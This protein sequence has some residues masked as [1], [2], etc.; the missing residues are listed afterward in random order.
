MDRRPGETTRRVLDAL[1]DLSPASEQRSSTLSIPTEWF[2]WLPAKVVRLFLPAWGPGQYDIQMRTATEQRLSGVMDRAFAER[3]A[4]IDQIRPT[5]RSLRVG[6][7]FVAG[8]SPA[9]EGRRQRVFHPLVTVPVRIERTTSYLA[10]AG[11]AELSELITD[12]ALRRELEDAI[13]VGGGALDGITEVE[14]PDGLLA[15]LPRLQAFA[16]SAAAAAHLPARELVPAGAG[17]DALMRS[18]GLR[19][20]AGAGIYAVHEIGGSSRAGSLRAWATEGLEEP[21]AFHWLYADDLA[22]PAPAADEEDPVDSPYLLTPVQ[23]AAVRSS[24]RRPV[25]LVSGAPGT[26]KSQTVVAIACDALARG[27]HVLV[28]AKSDA[29]VD[30]LLDLLERAPGPQPVLFGSNE[31]R[32]ALAARLAAGQLEPVSD[33]RLASARADLDEACNVRYRLHARLA[34]RLRAE[35]MLATPE[36]EVEQARVVA[37]SL[38]DPA[39]DLGRAGELLEA[40]GAHDAS[41]WWARHEAGKARRLLQAQAGAG[42]EVTVDELGR[43]I[44]VARSARVTADLLAGGGLDIDADWEELLAADDRARRMLGTWLAV[45]SRSPERVNR[46]TLPAVAA[47]ATALRSGRAAR[48]QQLARLSHDRLTRA[49]PLWVGTL[50]DVDDLLPPIAGLFDLVILDEASSIDQPLAAVTLLRG[51]RAVIAGDPHQ[52]RHVSFLA[53]EHLQE[54]VTV[55][56]LD[57]SPALAARLDVRRNSIFDVAASVVPALTLGE[58]FR[59]DPHLMEF[60]ARRLYGGRVEIATR[61]PTTESRDCVRLVR[62]S[63]TRTEAGVIQ[64]EV[65]GAVVELRRL[66][67]TGAPSVGVVT[68]FRAQADALEAAALEAFTADELESLDLRIGT[69]HAFQ[70]NERDIIVASLG[71][72]PTDGAA[73]WRFVE[74]PH[75]FAVF[76]TRARRQMVLL[77]SADPPAGSLVEAYLAQADTPPGPPAPAAAAT[78]WIRTVAEHLALGGTEV[79]TAYPSGRHVIDITLCDRTRN[80]GIECD[81]HPDGP[82][83]HIE[84]HLALR[85]TG[86]DLIGAHRS[87][88][89]EHPGELAVDLLHRLRSPL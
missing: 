82:E 25:T 5:Q 6:W 18:D 74:D 49:L 62:T 37:P 39:T 81:V 43:C 72:G 34:D 47:L 38:F 15:R 12:R 53:D 73:S 86:W 4:A 58:H 30:A 61:R 44:A 69:V 55:H 41:G 77:Y 85:R 3:L 56:G 28:A 68:P 1:A 57:T 50:A 2:R 76:V 65:D 46:S 54:V 84:R 13:E 75:L 70:G 42:P 21:T 14:I 10:P 71:L 67:R 87:R 27:A 51:R 79:R 20:V 63:G 83:A 64:E 36:D 19:I 52:L 17:P 59:S 66:L 40:A 11:D 22:E 7:L 23:Q 16:R 88:W 78:A 8:Q 24:R 60:V 35:Q 31:R 45:E 29:T 48:R 32:D 26:G 9:G 80:V 33:A 89:G